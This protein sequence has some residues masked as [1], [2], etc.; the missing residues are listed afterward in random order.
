MCASVQV[1]AKYLAF[2]RD[3]MAFEKQ[4]LQPWLTKANDAA[5][6]LLKQPVLRTEADTGRHALH[7]RAKPSEIL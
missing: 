4:A 7:A 3:V 6:S 2:A 1:E 5:R